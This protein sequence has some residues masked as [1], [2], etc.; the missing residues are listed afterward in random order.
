VYRLLA[1]ADLHAGSRLAPWP[2]D[3]P[4]ATGGIWEPSLAQRWLNRCWD[5]MLEEMLALSHLD[6]IIH[7]G[8]AL[9][10][11]NPRNGTI[12]SDRRDDQVGG[13]IELLGPLAELTKHFYMIQGTNWH[14][15]KGAEDETDVARQLKAIPQPDTGFLAWPDLYLDMGGCVS[16]WAHHIG[17][18][19]NPL[20]EA[21][22]LLRALYILRVEVER[23]WGVLAPDVRL[24]GRAHRHRMISVSK[25]DWHGVCLPGWQLKTP[26]G[27]KM[28]PETLPEVGYVIVECEGGD[29]WVKARRFGLPTPHIERT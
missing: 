18:T 2:R 4:L 12:V 23:E 13:A 25:G 15:G 20:Y 1:I 11:T 24:I 28:S 27:Y 22:A 29:I 3:F 19:S 21:N 9:E 10:G 8:D 6:A 16:H 14:V 26:F 7:L 5:T 17:S